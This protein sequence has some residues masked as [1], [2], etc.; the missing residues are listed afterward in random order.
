M[1]MNVAVEDTTVLALAS[2]TGAVVQE[3]IWWYDV[4]HELNDKKYADL[5]R[6]KGYWIIVSL[7]VLVSTIGPLLLHHRELDNYRP[8]DFMIFGAGFPLF[9]KQ[10]S[11]NAIRQVRK[12]KLGPGDLLTTYLLRKG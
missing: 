11:G 4:R 1:T 3:L 7:T 8:L 6:S 2:F 12:T 5:I 9:F 10:L